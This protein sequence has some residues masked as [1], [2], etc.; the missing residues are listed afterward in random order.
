MLIRELWSGG[1][2]GVD[3]AALDVA[4]ELGIPHH[5]W[6][7]AGRLAEDGPIGPEYDGLRETESPEYAVRTEFNVQDTD[8]TL[9]LSVGP[10]EGG[11]L[12]TREVAEHLARPLLIVDLAQVDSEDAARGVR[13]WL[14]A[15]PGPVRLNVAGPRASTAP[16]AYFLAGRFLRLVLP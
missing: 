6:I 5:G 15:L 10:L 13:E 16:A 11:T 8:A 9:L 12:F 4:R 2:T 3:R 1:Q 14:S 7:P